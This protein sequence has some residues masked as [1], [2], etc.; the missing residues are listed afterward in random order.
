MAL[1]DT[2]LSEWRT[3][4][5]KMMDEAKKAKQDCEAAKSQKE[6]TSNREKE[7]LVKYLDEW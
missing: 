4:K 3:E 5:N 7:M 1:V 2:K 6:E